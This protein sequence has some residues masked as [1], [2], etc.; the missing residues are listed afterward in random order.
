M[1]DITALL[2]GKNKEMAE[3]AKK[4][5]KKLKEDVRKKGL[6]LPVTENG[7]KGK[8]KMIA[9]CRFFEDGLR[10]CS[11]EGV[12]M[13]DSVETLGVR[14]GAKEKKRRNKAVQKSHMKVRVKKLLRAG[15]VPTRTWGVHEMVPEADGSS[16]GKEEYDFS[17]FIH[18]SMWP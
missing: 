1:D 12:M 16:S 13:A 6:K 8:S 11:K 14:L 17:V 5:M 3:M 15:M 18:G 2:M 7:K 10:Q 4:V 9:S